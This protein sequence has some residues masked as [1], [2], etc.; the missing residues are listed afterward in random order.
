MRT[1]V[2]KTFGEGSMPQHP[3]PW[4]IEISDL[5]GSTKDRDGNNVATFDVND[6]LEFWSALVKIVNEHAMLSNHAAPAVCR[7][8]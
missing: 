4:S 6:D 3:R 8:P 5:D 2:T 1:T 7:R